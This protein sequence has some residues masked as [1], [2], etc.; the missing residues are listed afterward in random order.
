MLRGYSFIKEEA[1]TLEYKVYF[2]LSVSFTKNCDRLFYS[3]PNSNLVFPA[4]SLYGLDPGLFFF[5]GDED[6]YAMF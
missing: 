2:T 5:D 1:F 3:R 6:Y 4:F